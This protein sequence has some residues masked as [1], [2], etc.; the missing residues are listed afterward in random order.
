MAG[1]AGEEG[2]SRHALKIHRGEK[3]TVSVTLIFAVLQ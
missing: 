3:V 2:I 1:D